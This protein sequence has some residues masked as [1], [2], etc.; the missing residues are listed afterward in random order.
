M[1]KLKYPHKSLEY[2]NDPKKVNISLDSPISHYQE[3]VSF[4]ADMTIV[5]QQ[6]AGD[7]G[8]LSIFNGIRGHRTAVIIE[9]N[10]VFDRQMVIKQIGHMLGCSKQEYAGMTYV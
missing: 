8:G 4:D 9:Q 5:I 1:K 2:F 3:T 10:F 6:Q 7:H